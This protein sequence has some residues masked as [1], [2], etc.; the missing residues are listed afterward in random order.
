[1]GFLFP[2][3]KL[4]TKSGYGMGQRTN[5]PIGIY[6]AAYP[7]QTFQAIFGLFAYLL[8]KDADAKSDENLLCSGN[9]KL[10]N[11]FKISVNRVRIY[12]WNSFLLR[13]CKK[14]FLQTHY[15]M[16]EVK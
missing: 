7:R 12:F 11:N 10:K 2:I 5:S 4:A 16:E 8:D 1:M 15:L 13:S 14:D 3:T 9:L 6:K